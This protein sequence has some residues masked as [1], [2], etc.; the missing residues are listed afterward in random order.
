MSKRVYCLD[1][2]NQKSE[3]MEVTPMKQQRFHHST[4][5]IDNKIAVSGGC[6]NAGSSVELYEKSKLSRANPY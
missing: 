6:N 1:L 4:V 2:D 3:W 5:I